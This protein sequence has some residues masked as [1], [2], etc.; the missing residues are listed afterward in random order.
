MIPSA[1]KYIKSRNSLH[2]TED[3]VLNYISKMS[4]QNKNTNQK[5]LLSEL[6]NDLIR[7]KKDKYEKNAF[8]YFDYLRWAKNINY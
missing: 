1:K 3:I 5:T 8:E 6:T 4:K 2:K 7:F